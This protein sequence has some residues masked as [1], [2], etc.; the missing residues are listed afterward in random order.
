M[1]WLMGLTTTALAAPARYGA[2]HVGTA[3]AEIGWAAAGGAVGWLGA[4]V[5]GALMAEAGTPIGDRTALGLAVGGTPYTEGGLGALASA[6]V[7]VL[8]QPHVRVA[9]TLQ[10][11]FASWAT[12]PGPGV[13]ETRLSP[14]IALDAGGERWRFDLSLP[15]SGLTTVNRFV[16]PTRVPFP[17]GGTIGVSSVVGPRKR[18]RLRFG[19]PEGL[20]WHLTTERGFIDVG[21]FPFV[22]GGVFVRAGFYARPRAVSEAPG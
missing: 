9:P 15:V 3:P 4:Q 16:G 18:A 17:L 6:R 10:L 20:S 7:V 19:L 13:F 12:N 5:G 22:I 2:L 8:D 11:A 1:W 14:G 21:G